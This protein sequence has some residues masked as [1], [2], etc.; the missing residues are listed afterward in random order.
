MKS[1]LFIIGIIVSLSASSQG[2][3]KR[4]HGNGILAVPSPVGTYSPTNS[5]F[6]RYAAACMKDTSG[7][8]WLYSSDGYH[9]LWRYN[10]DINEWMLA[11]GNTTVQLAPVYGTQGVAAAANQPGGATFGHPSWG[12]H[13]GNL[14]IF[15]PDGLNDMW[16]YNIATDMWTWVKGT[17]SMGP[18]VFGIKGIASAA[19]NPGMCN[20]TDCHWTDSNGE[21]WLYTEFD[22]NLWKFDPITEMWT[23]M[24][25]NGAANAAPV[26]GTIDVFDGANTPGGFSGCPAVGT[27][28]T[29]WITSD[30]HLWMMVNRSDFV[31]GEVEMWEYNPNI[32]EWR[33]RR[34][35]ALPIGQPQVYPTA[36]DDNDSTIFPIIRTEMRAEWVDNCDHLYMFGGG[37]FCWPSSTYNDLWRYDPATNN[38]TYIRGGTLP[39]VPGI[40]GVFDSNNMPPMVCG[41]QAWQNKNGFY[42][43]GGDNGIGFPSDDLWLYSPDTVVADF[44][45]IINCSDVTFSNLSTTGCNY[46]KSISWDFGDNT[47]ST[48]ENPTHAYTSNG[49]YEVTL[50]VENCSWNIDTIKQNIQIS[51]GLSVELENDTICTGDCIDLIATTSENPDSLSFTWS[52][53]AIDNDTINVCPG[54]TTSYTV[55]VTNQNG[56]SDSATATIVVL[57]PP[58]VNLGNDT[59]ICGGGLVLDAGNPGATYQWQDGS[60]LQFYNVTTSGD[61]FVMVDNGGCT[62]SDTV[63]IQNI[64]PQ[65]NLGADTSL[66]SVN[67]VLDAGNP[68][69]SYL[70]QDQSTNQLLAVT[71]TGLYYVEVTDTNGCITS[72]TINIGVGTLNV[73]LGNDTVLCHGNSLVL[74]AGNMGSNFLWNTGET[75]QSIT[76]NSAGIYSV[77]VADNLCVGADSI[78]VD[79]D[80]LN[81]SFN[82]EI[83]QNCDFFSLSFENFTV[84]QNVLDWHWDFG[85]NNN[86]TTKSPNHIYYNS[87]TYQVNLS[88]QTVLGCV[89]D[90]TVLIDVDVYKTPE[91]KFSF[92]PKPP[93]LDEPV[94]FTDES[95]YAT[96]W[97]WHFGNSGTSTQQHPVHQFPQA[98]DYTIKL[99]VS[100]HNCTDTAWVYIG[101]EEELIF[102]VPNTFT[103]DGD[104]FNNQFQPVFTSGYNPYDYHLTIFNRWGE[105]I[106]ESFDSKIGWDGHY[107]KC[108]LVKDGVYVWQIEFGNVNNDKRH[109][110]RGHVTLL[111]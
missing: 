78:E 48:L 55:M 35:D 18:A 4:V 2:Y 109:L 76:A 50:I 45:T 15:G 107:P 92:V 47:T 60:G 8:F 83:H 33:C 20:E 22:G 51:C 104:Q 28:Y 97:E 24:A 17:N 96:S 75:S 32:N 99:I 16:K 63:I 68:A 111:R 80:I 37:E 53:G 82:Y 62:G 70:W 40:Q 54:T 71:D 30:D 11:N 25:G 79:I 10:P 91:A 105:I 103:P 110:Y 26:Y 106:F 100:N 23:W 19:T 77:L 95:L 38:Y 6:S 69:A 66:C 64:G 73:W 13:M 52:F 21:L 102:Y 39:V 43:M 44:S 14:W 98:G 41:S 86:S 88:A 90:T 93:Q 12:D 46:F 42:L 5:P 74:D 58:V 72:D 31:N 57:P 87:G 29:M 81:V 65:V 101:L 27:L 108:N 56:F 1:I 3:W 34:I 89:N 94:E 67:L 9:E 7:S 49:T 36:C 61:F 84:G 59:T 85:D